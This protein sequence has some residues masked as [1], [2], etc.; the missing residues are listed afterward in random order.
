MDLLI[1]KLKKLEK[2][3][4]R[5][6]Q[7]I[8]GSYDFTDFELFFDHVQSDPHASAS[9]VR[10]IRPWSVTGLSWLKDS[11]QEFQQGARDFIAR[12]FARYAAQD[13]HISVA[14]TG[15]TVLDSTAVV[16]T[17]QGIELRFRINLPADGRSILA[18]KAIN[19]I[20]FHLP[21]Y[22]RKATLERELDIAGLT[23]HCHAI[24]DQAALR[25]QLEENGLCAF[26]A[27]GS[28]LPS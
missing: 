7:Q 14:L 4:Y 22:I 25:A 3:N 20:T 24:E 21:K 6:Y 28:V 11:S 27:N 13:N 19:L 1:A 16:F 23:T 5:A 17:D 8:K 12:T 9:R 10:A 15:Q 26:V 2:Q 18:K